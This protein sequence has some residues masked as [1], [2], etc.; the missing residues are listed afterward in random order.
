MS[1]E[2]KVHSSA[3]YLMMVLAVVIGVVLGIGIYIWISMNVETRVRIPVYLLA[4]PTILL[5]GLAR[6]ID[7][8]LVKRQ[9]SLPGN[10]NM[11]PLASPY[12]Q[13][14]AAAGYGQ[15]DAS[16]GYG[17]QSPQVGGATAYG[18][19]Q[20]AT[21][22]GQ[23]QQPG[24]TAPTYGQPQQPVPGSG[25]GE[26]QAGATAP[27]YGQAQQPGPPAP[28]AANPSSPCPAVARVTADRPPAT[29]RRLRRTRSRPTVRTDRRSAESGCR[30]DAQREQVRTRLLNN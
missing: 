8:A 11:A 1:T 4:L 24:A 27:T 28:T 23:A 19:Q 17:Q 12:G 21:G 15:P 9:Q 3:Y 2:N 16:M 26:A 13:A 22:Y 5:M 20:A 29:T 6:L 7:G 10:Q 18:Q 30:L 14:Q 25:Y